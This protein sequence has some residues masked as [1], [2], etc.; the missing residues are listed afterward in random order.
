VREGKRARNRGDELFLKAKSRQETR[1]PVGTPHTS[2]T[3]K[4]LLNL[5]TSLHTLLH[6]IKGPASNH[7]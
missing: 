1:Q 5:L 2:S 4:L 6:L 7:G 3:G